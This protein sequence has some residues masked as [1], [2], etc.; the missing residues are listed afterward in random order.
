M[1]RPPRRPGELSFILWP[2]L[3]PWASWTETTPSSAPSCLSWWRGLGT[4]DGTAGRRSPQTA[5]TWNVN[6]RSDHSGDSVCSPITKQIKCS[7]TNPLIS[8][9]L[10]QLLG[11]LL[12][13]PVSVFRDI[14]LPLFSGSFCSTREVDRV[15]EE[16]VARHPLADH[17]RH[18]FSR[19]NPDRNLE[20]VKQSVRHPQL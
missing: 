20:N 12:H 7:A 11:S 2:S 6:T 18:H 4:P 13:L 19:V 9:S 14:N 15:S 16:A 10:F 1:G 5:N 17:P 8:L 3:C